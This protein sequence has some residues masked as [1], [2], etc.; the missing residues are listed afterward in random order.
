MP[1]ELQVPL[2][3]DWLGGTFVLNQLSSMLVLMMSIWEMIVH[4]SQGQV[5]V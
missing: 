2:S 3:L 1:G 5:L 4:M